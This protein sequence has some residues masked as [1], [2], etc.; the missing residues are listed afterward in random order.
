MVDYW[1]PGN[2]TAVRECFTYVAAPFHSFARCIEGYSSY[3]S[4]QGFEEEQPFRLRW[5]LLA[6]MVHVTPNLFANMRNKAS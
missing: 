1:Q 4:A 2:P 3:R 6:E 5:V